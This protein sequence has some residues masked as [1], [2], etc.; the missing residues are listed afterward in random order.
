MGTSMNLNLEN[1]KSYE[2]KCMDN[3]NQTGT[4]ENLQNLTWNNLPLKIPHPQ[5]GVGFII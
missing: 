4:P 1:S 2:L 5:E 3:K